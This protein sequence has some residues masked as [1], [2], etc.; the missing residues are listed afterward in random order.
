MMTLSLTPPFLRMI[1]DVMR[2]FV[3]VG[4]VDDIFR[5]RI[6]GNGVFATP[7][8]CGVSFGVGGIDAEGLDRATL[9]AISK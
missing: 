6:L 3:K 8:G 7:T 5:P 4:K 9:D 1:P 2:P